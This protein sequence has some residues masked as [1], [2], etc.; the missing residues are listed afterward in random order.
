VVNLSKQVKAI[1]GVILFAAA[2][3]AAFFAY[4]M[5]LDRA[6][7][8]ESIAEVQRDAQL[9]PDFTMEDELGNEIRLSDLRGK[10][11]ILNF[12]ASWCPSCVVE[13]TYFEALY[14]EMED[15]IHILKVNLIGSRGETRGH[16]DAFMR[17]GD[18]TFPVFFD[19]LQ[20]GSRA[21]HFAQ[22]P[23]T[24]FISAEGY[25]VAHAFGAVNA[26][27]LQSGLDLIMVN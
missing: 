7:V 11:V 16:V 25:L 26:G 3:T 4:N 2:I 10:P 18:Y 12:W 13:T 8:P 14:R 15:D 20:D 17:E 27:V 23:L 9:A 19:T 5:L 21:Y 24:F 6:Y 1:L 22:F